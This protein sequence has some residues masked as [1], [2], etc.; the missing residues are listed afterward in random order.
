MRTRLLALAII[1]LPWR[2]V[3]G[4]GPPPAGYSVAMQ[5][6][7]TELTYQG[8]LALQAPRGR[9]TLNGAIVGAALGI[10]VGII[11]YQACSDSDSNGGSGGECL[12]KAALG[13]GVVTGV[14][15]LIGLILGG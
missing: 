14:G 3:S 11:S 2:S 12:G 1:C 5:G 6:A 15:A 7:Q 13:F 8:R 10:V 4:Q 9:S